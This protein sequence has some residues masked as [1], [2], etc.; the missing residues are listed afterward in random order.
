METHKLFVHSDR[1][2]RMIANDRVL[3][4]ATVRWISYQ[5]YLAKTDYWYVSKN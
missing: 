3:D 1:V 4:F 2:A 5:E